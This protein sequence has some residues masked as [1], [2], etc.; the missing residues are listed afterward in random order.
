MNGK[1]SLPRPMQISRT[2][3][4]SRHAMA[5]GIS[6]NE[7]THRCLVCGIEYASQYGADVCCE[8]GFTHDMMYGV[9]PIS[10]NDRKG[11]PSV[12]PK[13]CDTADR[14]DGTTR[15]AGLHEGITLNELA[16]MM[17]MR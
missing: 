16:H 11:E 3:Y 15:P 8:S 14:V 9:P 2:C 10:K 1:G 4:E 17:G 7:T 13:E 6:V 5:F 12:S